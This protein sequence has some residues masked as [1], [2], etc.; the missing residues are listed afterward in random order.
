MLDIFG[1]LGKILS[2]KHIVNRQADTERQKYKIK[3]YFLLFLHMHP[4][5]LSR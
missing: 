3:Q 4:R 1:N 5:T 2:A